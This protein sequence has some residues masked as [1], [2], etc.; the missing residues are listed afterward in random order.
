MVECFLFGGNNGKRIIE[1]AFLTFHLKI[2]DNG[3]ETIANIGFVST[4]NGDFQC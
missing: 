3:Q 1:I 4:F 2:N